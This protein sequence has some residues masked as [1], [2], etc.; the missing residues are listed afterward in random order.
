M[1][2]EQRIFM[3]DLMSEKEIKKHIKLCE[4]IHMQQ[5]SYSTYH[6]AFTQVCFDCKRIRTNIM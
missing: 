3:L 5:V 6:N 2:D 1:R 4:G